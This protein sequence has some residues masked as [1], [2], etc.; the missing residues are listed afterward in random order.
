MSDS[1]DVARDQQNLRTLKMLLGIGLVALIISIVSGLLL[2]AIDPDSG[3]STEATLGLTAAIGGLATGVMAIAALIY[4]QVK[5]LWKLVPTP[6]RI[7][8]WAFIAVGV[9]ITLW[10][11][12]SQPFQN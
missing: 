8:L 12:V 4:A 2:L 5:N 3:S 9:A 11:L 7:V 10:N 6:L 1:D